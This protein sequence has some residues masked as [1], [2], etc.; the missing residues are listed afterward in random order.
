MQKFALS[1]FCLAAFS[2]AQA[3]SDLLLT[4]CTT[5]CCDI[6]CVDDC[7]APCDGCDTICTGGFLEKLKGPLSGC[8]SSCWTDDCC[9]PECCPVVDD[10]CPDSCDGG[11][12]G[13]GCLSGG[14]LAGLIKSTDPCFNDFISPMTNPVMFEDPRTLS[15]IRFIYINHKVPTALA[16]GNLNV[17]A[18]Q[19][20]VALSERLSLIATKDGFITSSNGII[21]DGF[22]DV[23]AGLK[24]NLLRDP[25]NGQLV[26]VGATYEMPIGSTRAFQGNGDGE[27]DVFLS[28]GTRLGEKMHALAATGLRLP[29]DSSAESSMYYLSAHLDYMVTKKAYFL[30]EMNWYNWFDGGNV[31]IVPGIEG[32]D[33]INLGAPGVAGNNIVTWAWGA[34]FKPAKNQELGVAYEIPISSR[35]DVLDNRLTFDYIY[36][37]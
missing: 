25:Q 37:F 18:A 36:R 26:S 14:H 27:F 6:P 30:T 10:C 22:A 32:G 7:C 1:L 4:S 9:A 24:Y 19:V 35:N 31:G 21:G 17:F 13:G 5:E 16:G 28:G 34:K 12:F 11:C 2:V 29:V 15:E 33:L 3:D 23:A 8:K 20:R